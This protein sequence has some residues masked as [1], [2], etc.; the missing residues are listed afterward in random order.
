MSTLKDV[1]ADLERRH[2]AWESRLAS[3]LAAGHYSDAN[4]AEV[5]LTEIKQIVYCVDEKL[6]NDL[7]RNLH[8]ICALAP[9]TPEKPIKSMKSFQQFLESRDRGWTEVIET[10]LTEENYLEAHEADISRLVVR[11]LLPVPQRGR[12]RGG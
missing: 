7:G 4:E 1:L 2:K 5:T 8:A 11:G 10:T 12:R 6:S 3:Y 9:E